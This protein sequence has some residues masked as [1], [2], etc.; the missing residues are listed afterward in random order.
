MPTARDPAD[1]QSGLLTADY[2]IA[3]TTSD[4]ETRRT[5]L[6]LAIRW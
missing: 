4:P 2:R 5:L 3:Q 1:N 6:K